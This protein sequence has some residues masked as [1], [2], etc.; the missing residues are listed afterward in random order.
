METQKPQ[1]KQEDL[2]YVER[3]RGTP[4]AKMNSRQKVFFIA[5]VAVCILTFGMAF[6][7]VMS[8]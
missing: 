3:P 8:D 7:N 6:P 2:T 5:K 4:Y 1:K